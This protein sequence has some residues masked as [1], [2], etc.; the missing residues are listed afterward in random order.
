[1]NGFYKAI[2]H[3]CKACWCAE[4]RERRLKNPA[5]Q[6]YDRRRAKTPERRAKA[7]TITKRWRLNHPTGNKAQA[8]VNYAVRTG[9]L[10]KGPCA[11]CG[12]DKHIH[13]HHRDYEKPLDVTWLCAKCHHR[14]HATFPEL[15]G[16]YEARQ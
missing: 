7:R 1:M 8:A 9:Q 13:A 5:V 16:H 10:V 2:T 14:L 4:V 6:E 11:I 12:T 3:V 15:G